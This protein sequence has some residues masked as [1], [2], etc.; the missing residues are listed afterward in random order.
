MQIFA[1]KLNGQFLPN[2]LPDEKVE[3]DFVRA[4]IAYGNDA[5]TLIENCLAN[6]RRLDIWMRY[7]HTVPVAPAL[8]RKLLASASSNIF[9]TLISDVLHSKVIWWK[10]YGVYVG[11]ANLTDRAWMT[12]IEFGVFLPE[13]ELESAGSLGEIEDFFA[14]LESCEAAIGLTE[15]IVAEQEAIQALR[16]KQI[17]SLDTEALKLRSVKTWGGPVEVS[18]KGKAIDKRRINFVKEWTEGLTFLR[19]IAQQAP[20][21]R[22]RWLHEDVPP[23]W[24]ADQ[25]LHAYYYNEVQDGARHPYEDFYVKHRAD[26]AGAVVRTLQWWSRLP[27]PPSHEDEHCHVRAPIIQR[28]L[29]KDR[30][31]HITLEDFIEVCAANHST[32]DHVRRMR[33]SVLGLEDTPGATEHQRARAFASWLWEKRNKK[34]ESVVDL[35]KYVLDGGPA[36]ELPNRIFDVT[37]L[38]ERKLA[39]FGTNQVAELAGWA[40]PELCPP[41]NGRTSKG[42]RALGYDVRIY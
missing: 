40:R 36:K 30:L 27:D 33:L 12:N 34:G 29:A 1:N 31:A 21:F 18:N 6:R 16:S 38:E 3:I 14:Q 11:S 37:S 39:H 35:L 7:D 8:L 41:R 13:S 2:V 5:T 9:C 15:E 4:A 42:L 32:M 20:D 25:F 19:E 26:P 17:H 22:P 10:R 28:F 24:Q 23:A